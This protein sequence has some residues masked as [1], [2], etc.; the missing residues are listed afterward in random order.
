M[1]AVTL[2]WAGGGA[3]GSGAGGGC[4]IN[5]IIIDLWITTWYYIFVNKPIRLSQHAKEQAKYRGCTEEEVKEA[6]QTSQREPAE[7]G[8]LQCRKDFVFNKIWNDK[9]YQTKQVKPIF[10]EQKDEIVVI[11]VYI[12]YF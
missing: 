1:L 5:I 9:E 3:K 4:I 6:I 8:R 7:L 2:S 11:T 12:Y 10:M